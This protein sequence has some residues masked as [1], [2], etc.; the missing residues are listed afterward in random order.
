MKAGS[1]HGKVAIVTGFASGI[2][3]GTAEE[4]AKRGMRLVGVDIDE[5]LGTQMAARLKAD[6]ADAMFV[7]ADVS[8]SSE[9]ENAIRVAIEQFGRVDVLHNNAGT[10]GRNFV[11]ISEMGEDEW[12]RIIAVNLKGVFLGCKHV[13]PCMRRNGGGV[14]INT[15]SVVGLVGMGNLSAYCASKGG[16]I[17]LTRSLARELAPFNIRVNC[18]CPGHTLTPNVERAAVQSGDKDTYLRRLL[19]EVPAVIKRFADSAK[20]AKGVAYLASDDANFIT[21]ATLAIDGGWSA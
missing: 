11:P 14:I 19:E 8:K 12:D 16:V 17:S 21:G 20:I 18:V 6:G 2:G 9:V 3:R 1:S 5:R 10:T 7:R 4:F 13:V 15:A